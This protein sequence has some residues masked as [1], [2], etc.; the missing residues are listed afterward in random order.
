[1]KELRPPWNNWH[2]MSASIPDTVLAPNDPLRNESIFANRQSAHELERRVVRAGIERWTQARFAAASASGSTLEDVRYFLR[3][4]LETTTFNLSSAN[5]QSAEINAD[6]VLTLPPTFFLNTDALLD[7]I[8]LEPDLG[9]IRVPGRLYRDSLARYEFALTDG[10]YK[11]AG[12][13]FFAFLVPEPAFE[14]INVLSVLL[15][16]RVLSRR[17]AACLLMID[18]QNP[19]LS[20]RRKRLMAYVPAQCRLDSSPAPGLRADLETAFVAALEQAPAG[21]DSPEA[22]FL[23]NWR[24]P[25]S[26]Y[27]REFARRIEAY[28]VRLSQQG[29]IETGFDGWVRLAES[30]RRFFRR[31]PLA[32]FRLTTPVTNIPEDAPLLEMVSDGTVRTSLEVYTA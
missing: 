2:S 16:E 30:R 22:E 23:A 21:A 31:R 26:A 19:I 14:D 15:R 13:T 5:Q 20:A 25:E 9:A 17:F 27:Q 28:F 12:D 4:V 24:L 11:Q 8:G 6:S 3:Q 18:F 7:E 29:Q 32:E 10:T 1:M